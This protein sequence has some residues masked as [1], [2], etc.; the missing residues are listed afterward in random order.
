MIGPLLAYLARQDK[1]VRTSEAHEGVADDLGL[2]DENRRELLPSGNQPIYKNRIGWAHDALKRNGLSASPRRGYWQITGEGRET[3]ATAG[4]QLS[5][6]KARE[7]AASKRSTRISDLVNSHSAGG[8]AALDAASLRS[9][10]EEMIESGLAEIGGSVAR[11]LNELIYAASPT[12][13]EQLVLDLLHAMGYGTDRRALQ[14]VGGSG[15]GGIDG[16]ISLDRLGLEKV[17]V[18]AKRWQNQV[19]SPEVQTFVGALQLRGATK[20]VLISPG[21]ITRPA[22]AIAER[23]NVVLIDGKRLTQL[24]IEYGI[25]VSDRILKVPKVDSDYFHEL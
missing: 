18:Q 12:F 23:A 21:P 17:Y 10:P 22:F 1:P 13:F 4:G 9:S 7:I 15:D 11:E 3:L 19:G 16:V 5:E 24:M 8:E 14:H 25:G 6:D 20:G 2:T